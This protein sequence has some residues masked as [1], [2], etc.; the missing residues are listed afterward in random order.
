[1]L[2]NILIVILTLSALWW[3]R[4]MRLMEDLRDL[5]KLPDR[6]DWLKGNLGLVLMGGGHAQYIFNP[7][8]CWWVEL[9]SLPVIYLGPNYGGGNEDNSHLLQKDPGMYCYTQCPQHCSRRP[10]THTSAGNSW[11]L[12]GMSGSFSC[13]VTAPFSWVLVH[14]RF[15]LCPP[16]VCFPSPV[17]LLV[18]LWWD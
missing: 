15:C 7:I 11:T 10:L 14:T 13:A 4:L 17:E 16:K 6:R 12:M 18:V 2:G 3:R 9:C 5:W 8:F 1:M